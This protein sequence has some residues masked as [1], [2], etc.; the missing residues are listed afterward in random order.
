MKALEK[1]LVQEFQNIIA[2]GC[3]EDI[4]MS[5]AR[6]RRSVPRSSYQG[7]SRDVVIPKAREGDNDDYCSEDVTILVEGEE[8][9]SSQTGSESFGSRRGKKRPNKQKQSKSKKRS[10]C[11]KQKSRGDDQNENQEQEKEKEVE[12]NYDDNYADLGLGSGTENSRDKRM[13]KGKDP[14]EMSDSVEAIDEIERIAALEESSEGEQQFMEE[15]KSKMK[16]NK[17]KM[18]DELVESSR[19]E[20]C[21]ELEEELKEIASGNR[22]QPLKSILRKEVEV[23]RRFMEKRGKRPEWAMEEVLERQNNKEQILSSS[24]AVRTMRYL[25]RKAM[26]KW[27]CFVQRLMEI[28]RALLFGLAVSVGK[29]NHKAYIH[30]KRFDAEAEKRLLE[31]T[32]N[33]MDEEEEDEGST[34]QSEQYVPEYTKLIPSTKKLDPTKALGAIIKSKKKK[35][36]KEKKEEKKRGKRTKKYGFKIATSQKR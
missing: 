28:E 2:E 25:A 11:Q 4:E 13:D 16:E 15:N 6:E 10:K 27:S 20:A 18:E 9:R 7:D 22:K 21:D 12:E 33:N 34:R 29:N 35:K 30:K 23:L 3:Q 32:Q 36:D 17:S 1:G 14:F 8:K 24:T 26:S 5:E 31:Q 19:V